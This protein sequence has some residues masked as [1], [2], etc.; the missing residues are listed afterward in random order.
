MPTPLL[1]TM[2]C[3]GAA[4]IK[5]PATNQINQVTMPLP[6]CIVNGNDQPLKIQ[7]DGGEQLTNR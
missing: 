3:Q 2:E 6:V 1:L 7:S 5:C 4:K